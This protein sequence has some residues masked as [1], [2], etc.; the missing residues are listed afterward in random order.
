VDPIITL[1]LIY[2]MALFLFWLSIALFRWLWNITMPQVFGLRTITFWQ[3]FRL[4]ILA[5]I[6]FEGHGLIFKMSLPLE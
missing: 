6:L 1:V 4:M 5:G 3:A 2:A